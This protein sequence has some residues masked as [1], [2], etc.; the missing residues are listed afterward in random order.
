MDGGLKG[1][2]GG[3]IFRVSVGGLETG[4]IGEDLGREGERE[5]G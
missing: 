1:G 3:V 2:E 5:G 4:E